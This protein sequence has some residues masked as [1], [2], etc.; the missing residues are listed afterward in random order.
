VFLYRIHDT[1]GDGLLELPAPEPRTRGQLV[2]LL[3]VA[4]DAADERRLIA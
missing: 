4:T 3:E 1:T 2:A